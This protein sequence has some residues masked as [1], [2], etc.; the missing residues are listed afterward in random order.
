MNDLASI[1]LMILEEQNIESLLEE[2]GMDN[3]SFEQGGSLVTCRLPERFNSTNNR[4]VQIRMNEHLTCYIRNRS[5]FKGDIYSLVSYIV[6]DARDEEIN[7]TLGKA[8]S[9]ICEVFGIDAKGVIK[10]TQRTD[11][12]KRLKALAKKANNNT[13]IPNV[14]IPEDRL[15]LYEDLYPDAWV[16]EGLSRTALDFF[17]VRIDMESGRIIIPIRNSKGQLVG[18]KGRGHYLPYNSDQKYLYLDKADG[19]KDLYGFWESK[20]HIK[21]KK[22]VYVFEGEK[23]V[24]KCFDNRFYNVVS[25]GSSSISER[26]VQLINSLGEDIQVIIAFDKGKTPDEIK[27]VA[28][29]FKNN[30]VYAIIDT[31]GLISESDSPIDCGFDVFKELVENCCFAIN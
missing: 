19:S 17:G 1:K 13:F 14:P 30:E 7:K 27:K 22:Q 12:A 26:Q 9:F 3:I 2:M 6:F 20:K 31:L 23:S 4:A 10:L 15:N 28:E 11:Y 18:T 24:M 25:V 5:D 29:V 21:Q 16:K 8:K